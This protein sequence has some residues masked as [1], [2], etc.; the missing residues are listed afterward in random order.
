MGEQKQQIFDEA[1]KKEQ[2]FKQ[3]QEQLAKQNMVPMKDVTKVN[4][5]QGTGSVW[6]NNSYHWEEKSVAKWAEETLKRTLSLFY[7]K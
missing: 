6:N 3:Q 7:F 4:T 5:A 2:E 1:K